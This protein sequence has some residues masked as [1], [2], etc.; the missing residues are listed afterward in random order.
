[1]IIVRRDC[2]NYID[3]ILLQSEDIHT[4]YKIFIANKIIAN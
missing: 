4:S 1:M 3:N 2:P